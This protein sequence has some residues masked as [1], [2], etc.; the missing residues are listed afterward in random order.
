MR[1]IYDLLHSFRRIHQANEAYFKRSRRVFSLL[2][3]SLGHHKIKLNT[4]IIFILIFI[5]FLWSTRIVV[6]GVVPVVVVS[7]GLRRCCCF[8][9][10]CVAAITT[11]K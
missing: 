9:L 5:K 11:Y 4:Q 7:V 2:L 1:L 3:Q 6:V 10:V 8:A